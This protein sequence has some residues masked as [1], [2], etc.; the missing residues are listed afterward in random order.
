VRVVA[1]EQQPHDHDRHRFQVAGLA[2][3]A[4]FAEIARS[5]S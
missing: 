5:V 1:A 3:V 4:A 2:Q